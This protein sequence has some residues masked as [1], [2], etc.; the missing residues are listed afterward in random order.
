MSFDSFGSFGDGFS[1]LMTILIAV[2]AVL[3]ISAIGKGIYVWNRN[4]HSPRETVEARV[5]AKRT[6]V[7]GHG[8][9][10]M[11]SN[12]A[13][14]SLGSSTYTN[15]FVTFEMEEGRRVELGVKDA[16]YG[17]LAEGDEGLLSFQGTRYLGFER[18][19]GT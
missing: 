19:S 9:T 6:K 15:Y 4:N 10:M 17:M 16:E 12:A 13:M 8:H 18:K 1:P 5:V 2:F 3:L 14:N 7:T 11:S